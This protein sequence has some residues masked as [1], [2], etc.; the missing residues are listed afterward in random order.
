MERSLKEA[1]FT[2][3]SRFF[4]R[5]T[6]LER[7]LLDY[8]NYQIN[9]PLLFEDSLLLHFEGSE[10]FI[11]D[12]APSIMTSVFRGKRV[13]LDS[14]N[15]SLDS[16]RGLLLQQ[17]L[18]TLDPE[19]SKKEARFVEKDG[20]LQVFY[21][22]EDS[23]ELLKECHPATLEEA[24]PILTKLLYLKWG[25]DALASGGNGTFADLLKTEK[26]EF[27][28]RLVWPYL[29]P[30]ISQRAKEE[31]IAKMPPSAQD[32]LLRHFFGGGSVTREEAYHALR[33]L[34]GQIEDPLSL[35]ADFEHRRWI[36][37]TLFRFGDEGGRH[38]KFAQLRFAELAE[39]ER[40]KASPSPGNDVVRLDYDAYL[41][42][43]S[44]EE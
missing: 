6:P 28:A 29:D 17:D 24:T 19:A 37:G 2:L 32:D 10:A 42:L 4:E 35:I 23:F 30:L 18:V 13:V 3:L 16:F 22:N 25:F 9:E 36:L 31:L 27:P 43:R 15:L 40:T 39:Q 14:D 12:I 26:P 8:L 33:E 38:R 21:K 20:V 5:L 11:K 34:Y 41:I 7:S 1:S 44:M